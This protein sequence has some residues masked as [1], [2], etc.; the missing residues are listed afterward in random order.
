MRL[1]MLCCAAFGSLS[2]GCPKRA[3]ILDPT[4]AH[5]VAEETTIKVWVPVGPNA[6]IKQDARLLPGD[7]C[8]AASAVRPP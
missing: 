2:L 8:A 7:W 3:A 1:V 6:L 4:K 5:E